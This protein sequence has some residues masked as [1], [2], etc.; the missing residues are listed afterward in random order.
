MIADLR[1]QGDYPYPSSYI[2]NG[3]GELPAYPVRVACDSLGEKDMAGERL[4]A[5]LAG[6]VGVF[7]NYSGTL[8]CLDYAKV[9]PGGSALLQGAPWSA[10]TTPRC[11]LSMDLAAAHVYDSIQVGQRNRAAPCSRLDQL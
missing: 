11:T 5:G 6:A 10:W 1:L 4:L 3:L 9:H 2:L 7:Y 8:E